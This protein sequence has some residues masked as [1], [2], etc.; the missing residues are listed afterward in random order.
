MNYLM[1]LS[2]INYWV[3][4]WS[5]LLS[6]LLEYCS[7]KLILIMRDCIKWMF[8]LLLHSLHIVS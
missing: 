2:S 3:S 8:C 7:A 1:E 4:L 5:F 6:N